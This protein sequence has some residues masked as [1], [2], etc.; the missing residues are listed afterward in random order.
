MLSLLTTHS[1]FILF[2]YLCE[3]LLILGLI[4]IC[5]VSEIVYDLGISVYSSHVFGF[6]LLLLTRE[7]V[8]V[9]SLLVINDSGSL[10]IHLL[11]LYLMSVHHSHDF[12]LLLGVLLCLTRSLTS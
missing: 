5:F 11:D 12:L 2:L 7:S 3:V 4:T 10:L 8:K 9:Y 1:L 6:D